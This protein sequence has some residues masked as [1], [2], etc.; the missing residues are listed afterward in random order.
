MVAQHYRWDFYG[1]STD[2]KP[3]ADNPKVANGSTYYE[4]NTSKLFVW[5]N[6]QW[7][8]KQAGGELPVATANTL[9]GIKVGDGLSITEG[10]VLSATGGGGGGATVLT[11][12]DFN[13]PAGSPTGICGWT[14]ADGEY[15]FGEEGITVYGGTD[16]GYQNNGISGNA[17]SR[18][19]VVTSELSDQDYK[20]IVFHVVEAGEA[21]FGY[22]RGLASDGS[23]T[24]MKFVPME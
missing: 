7:Y 14:L 24:Q 4:A 15:V 23:D 5:Y 18:I 1:L 8:E 3:T 2:S 20:V 16:S 22:T 11:S 13:Y 21:Y 12:A 9:G 6:D 10:G 19:N 17:G